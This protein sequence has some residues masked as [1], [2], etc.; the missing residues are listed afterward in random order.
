MSLIKLSVKI[1]KEAGETLMHSVLLFFIPLF[2]VVS[3]ALTVTNTFSAC[4]F[5]FRA[6][7]NQ[8]GNICQGAHIPLLWAF[9]ILDAIVL[10]HFRFNICQPVVFTVIWII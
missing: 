1:H 4:F 10:P 2:L 3:I 8:S 5:D 7:P 6:G 9:W